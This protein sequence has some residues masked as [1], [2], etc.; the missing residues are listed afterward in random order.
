MWVKMGDVA[1]VWV[2]FVCFFHYLR[3][4]VSISA[5]FFTWHQ[6]NI[7]NCVEALTR[8]SVNFSSN[9]ISNSLIA[10]LSNMRVIRLTN[11]EP[12]L[13]TH[14]SFRRVNMRIIFK[15]KIAL[16]AIPTYHSFQVCW[17]TCACLLKHRIESMCR[18]HN[19][20]IS[21]YE[22]LFLLS[23]EHLLILW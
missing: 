1:F 5:N 9:T 17:K 20:Y 23:K 2:L 19:F 14:Q 7:H 6:T 4:R 12:H 15:A 21:D 3:A 22:Q 11:C 8:S 16:S 10:G 18:S 13:A